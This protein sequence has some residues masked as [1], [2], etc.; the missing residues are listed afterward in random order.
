L[1]N[2]EEMEEMWKVTGLVLLAGIVFPPL[3]TDAATMARAVGR[4]VAKGAAK[5]LR[6]APGEILRRDLLRDRVTRVRPLP[7][8]RTVFRYTSKQRAT[9][10]LRRGIGPGSHMTARGGP[11]RPLG[12]AE[13]KRRYG[14][15]QEPQ[16]RET[17]RLSSGQGIRSNRAI[18]GKRGVGELTSPERLEG[19]IKRVV[20]LRS[21]KD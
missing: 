17:I 19:A 6:Q 2:R 20:P 8:D 12:S 3:E 7:K 1:Q 10:E 5:A 21:G 11:G 15:P 9:Q 13:A 14:L 18:G 16:A 4:G